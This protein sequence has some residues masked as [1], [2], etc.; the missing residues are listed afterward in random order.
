MICENVVERNMWRPV[1]SNTDYAWPINDGVK[2]EYIVPL[3]TLTHVCRSWRH[4]VIGHST[5]WAYTEHE[6]MSQP[7]FD[8]FIE[9]AGDTRLFHAFYTS[10]LYGV[11]R[12]IL[13]THS[14]RLRHL[15][16]HCDDAAA[17]SQRYSPYFPL[18]ASALECL[19]ITSDD[20][21]FEYD[22]FPDEPLPY[23]F[24]ERTSPIRALA[25]SPILCLIPR[26]SFPN[27]THLY[28]SFGRQTSRDINP[29]DD[30]L[31]LLSNAPMVRFLHVSRTPH[32]FPPQDPSTHPRLCL[33]QMRNITILDTHWQYPY[34]LLNHISLHEDTHV[35]VIDPRLAQQ[36]VED[37]SRARLP[38]VS[39]PQAK[40]MKIK[41]KNEGEVIQIVVEGPLDSTQRPKGRLHISYGGDEF[42]LDDVVDHDDEANTWRVVW[43]TTL[44]RTIL[45]S[46]LLTLHISLYTSHQSVFIDS[47]I[48]SMQKLVELVIL[49]PSDSGESARSQGMETNSPIF[50]CLLFLL[51]QNNP[52]ICPALSE[53]GVTLFIPDNRSSQ[54]L[55]VF[56]NILEIV[57]ARSNIG[58]PIRR[59]F[60]QPS[61]S[62]CRR[63]MS[64]WSNSLEYVRWRL[65]W[66]ADWLGMIRQVVE[67]VESLRDLEERDME[68]FTPG[69]FYEDEEAKAEQY[70]ELEG[71]DKPWSSL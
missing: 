35:Y 27:L 38:Q 64:T 7:L 51:Q 58:Y 19:S 59:F 22:D 55:P 61:K 31:K 9:R 30:L 63:Y 32:I 69:S 46:S 45:L 41:S 2:S 29:L 12:V 60:M 40:R 20:G 33:P 3:L 17:F 50:N 4:V 66:F 16:I 52:V 37:A 1:I 21:I 18:K 70:W 44:P 11:K 43:L 67:V 49:L 5:F 47:V 13:D 24:H 54:G 10:S 14:P 53:L 6:L 65:A 28:I 34:H 62:A 42:L 15:V 57:R 71:V 39:L 26:D 56:D 23:I 8:M 68:V 48:P 25:L 36:E